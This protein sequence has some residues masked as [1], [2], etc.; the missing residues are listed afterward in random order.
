MDTRGQPFAIVQGN[1]C[2]CCTI[3]YDFVTLSEVA[4]E[5][6]ELVQ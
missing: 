4:K 6:C 5:L 3:D 1:F 2:I